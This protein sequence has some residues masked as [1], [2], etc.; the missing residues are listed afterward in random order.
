VRIG[1]RAA[2][3]GR[4]V[5]FGIKPTR[6]ETGYGYISR[7]KPLEGTPGAFGV[8]KFVEKPARATAERFLASGDYLWNASLFL[9][10]PNVYREE[11]KKCAP[12]VS[13]GA[14]DPLARARRDLVFLTLDRGP[15]APSLSI[16]IDYGVVEHTDRAGVVPAD[17]GWS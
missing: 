8:A 16:P 13:V 2:R 1:A 17:I 15:C 14:R 9:F 4:L 7:G 12:R 5:T 11:L 10:P 6:A 3:S